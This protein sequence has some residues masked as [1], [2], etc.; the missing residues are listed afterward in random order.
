MK[1]LVTSLIV[2]LC[3][4][5]F[6]STFASGGFP[7]LL[8]E[9]GRSEALRD[10]QLGA[11]AGAFGFARML[12]DV[13]IGLFLTHHLRRA[14]VLGLGVIVAGLLLM[15]TSGSFSLLVLGRLL[16]GV[17]HA[18]V[19]MASLTALLRFGV[20]PRLAS[21]LNAFEFSAMLGFLGGTLLVGLLPASLGWSTAIL[22]A[23]TPMLLG[24]AALPALLRALP[25]GDVA[26]PRPLFARHAAPAGTGA[27]APMTTAVVLA[28]AA[29]GT[30]A[31][32]YS[33]IEQFMLPL[34]GSRTFDLE[35]AGIARLLMTM[36]I[37][38]VAALLPVGLLAD[39]VGAPRVLGVV[40]L[41]MAAATVLVAFGALPVVAAGC[42]LF[43]VA[44]A[45]WMLPL[46]VLRRETA[47]ERIA[48]RTGL[49][50]VF[51]D[52]GMFL[53]PFVAGLVGARLAPHL[54]AVCAV[55]LAV[56]GALFLAG[57]R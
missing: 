35:R 31:A 14:L 13:P 29:G 19:M 7:A 22:L 33:T 1:D 8:P 44:M 53:G 28:F 30:V 46:G 17:G 9:I 15:T 56:T 5:V 34:R 57:R 18:L 32:T 12:A 27:H 11:V 52:G 42:A 41:L 38:D 51:V 23:S 6:T 3:L 2:L 36:Q 10:W 25:S 39:R 16:L 43:G 45:G 37:S 55:A 21:S 20:G 48:W 26:G 54:G 4:L 49:Y 47:P 50:R 40:L 24:V